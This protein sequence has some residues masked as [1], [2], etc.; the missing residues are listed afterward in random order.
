[1]TERRGMSL[2]AIRSAVEV[3]THPKLSQLLAQ[4]IEHGGLTVGEAKSLL[5]LP[6]FMV[7]RFAD[8]LVRFGCRRAETDATWQP[9]PD[10]RST[11]SCGERAH[12]QARTLVCE[13]EWR[14]RT[15]TLSAVRP[16]DDL[17]V[18]APSPTGAA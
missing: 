1:M 6:P 2:D 16:A 18:W 15:P 10:A 3:T 8:H 14:L 4:L 7:Q 9:S 17:S 11:Q 5:D 13:P 12:E